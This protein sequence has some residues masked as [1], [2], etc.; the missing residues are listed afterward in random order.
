VIE[1]VIACVVLFPWSILIGLIVAA[2]ARRRSR[3][4]LVSSEPMLLDS[5]K[6]ARTLKE[7]RQ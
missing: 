3:K 4:A 5:A 1:L 6:I 7:T 2:V